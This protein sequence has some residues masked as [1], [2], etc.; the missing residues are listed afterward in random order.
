MNQGDSL[1]PLPA[2]GDMFPPLSEVLPAIFAVAFM[3]WA[4]YTAIAAY[5][6]LRYGADSWLSVPALVVHV[7]VSGLLILYAATGLA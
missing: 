7:F 5:H 1:A 6:W 3:L 2:L 4:L